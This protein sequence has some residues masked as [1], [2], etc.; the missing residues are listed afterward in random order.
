MLSIIVKNH[1]H[2]KTFRY[3]IMKQNR[4]K[5]TDIVYMI[6]VTPAK[7]FFIKAVLINNLGFLPMWKSGQPMKSV[8]AI[9]LN[10]K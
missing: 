8:F 2:N 7:S 1:A 10:R 9:N 4:I 3:G 6:I 5:N